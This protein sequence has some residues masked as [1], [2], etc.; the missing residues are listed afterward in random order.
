MIWI[1]C[2]AAAAALLAI[3]VKEYFSERRGVFR[4]AL[5]L[6]CLFASTYILY[7]PPFM[8]TYGILSGMIGNCV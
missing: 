3:G 8:D 4:V 5:V 1:I 2:A 6:G 7:I